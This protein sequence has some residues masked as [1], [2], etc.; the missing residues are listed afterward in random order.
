[1]VL[2]RIGFDSIIEG[3]A[4]ILTGEGRIDEQ[5]GWGK[6]VSEVARRGT[7]CGVPVIALAGQVDDVAAGNLGL[8]AAVNINPKGEPVEESMR[9]ASCRL[10][11]AARRLAPLLVSA[12]DDRTAKRS[13]TE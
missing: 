6:V 5:T 10:E 8:T 9:H 1:M 2:D 4:Y 3:A 13:I 12:C 11:E 7:A